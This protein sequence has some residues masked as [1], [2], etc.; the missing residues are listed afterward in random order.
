M[1][2]VAREEISYT[3]DQALKDQRKGVGPSTE[4]LVKI[5]ESTGLRSNQEIL[6]EGVV[7]S[8]MKE[9]AE[10][11]DNNT[12]AE[13]LEGLISLVTRMHDYLTDIKHAQ[14]RCPVRVPSDFRCSLS[15]E[16]MTDPVIVASGQ[17]YERVFIQKWIDMGLIFCPKTRQA[18]SHTTLTPNFIVRA[19]IASWCETHNVYP[20]DPLE[21]IQSSQPFPL[22]VQSGSGDDSG[23]YDSS[24]IKNAENGHEESLD[25]D[26]LRQVF[27]RSAS[28]PG[29]VS[30]VV[31]KTKRSTNAADTSLSLTRSN[32]PWQF[33]AERHW[34]HPGII[35][36]TTRETG[37][38]SSI[39]TEVKKLIEDLKSS[40]LDTQRE[41]TAQIRI[42]SRNSTDNR[43]V[44]A[45]GGAI[46]SLV[47]LLYSMDE[48][49]QADAVTCLL[50]LSINDN[51][52]SLIADSGA[53]E[54]LVH[55]LKTGYLEEAKANAA[56]TL[57]SLSVIEEYKTEIGNA[58]AIE[59]LV[60]LLG[61]GSLSGKKDAATALFNL[62]I[63]HEN[64]AKVIE[65]GAVRYLVELMDPSFG[66]VERAVVVLAN[67]ATVR[68]GK[69]AIGEEGGIRVLVE[70]VELGSAR[71][72]ENATAALLQL[73]THSPKFCNNVIREGVIPPLVA[74]TKS[75]TARGKEKVTCE[76][77]L[78]PLPCLIK[79]HLTTLVLICFRHRVF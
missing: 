13:Y 26:E 70:V 3:I 37:S 39:E 29:I 79:S 64:K 69:I 38:S 31:S 49:I 42:L 35:P 30:E 71:G 54:P 51:N 73:C 22:L 10:L 9:N 4:V 2:L 23:G 33:P 27:S 57:F 65:A 50:N 24:P 17:T 25:A 62:S 61:N 32:T 48:R 63:H 72:K 41:A 74:L 12:E 78:F 43:I 56:A 60:D 47:S 52:K 18:L 36:A 40:S 16:L 46:P 77:F 75:G 76:S 6:I 21:L 28:A 5:A 20:P 44:I 34:R 19:F 58:G 67:L 68:E 14:L 59:P 55:V 66:M 11:T 7:L 1:K 15:L 53:I 45:R 8:N